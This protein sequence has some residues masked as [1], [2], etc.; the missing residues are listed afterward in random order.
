MKRGRSQ[1]PS[2]Q[3]GYDVCACLCA[4]S[5]NDDRKY[6]NACF[7]NIERQQ[8]EHIPNRQ[9]PSGRKTKTVKIIQN[10]AKMF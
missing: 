9:K 2:I 6:Q 3:F 4:I 8:R 7:E 10:D 1:I 5:K